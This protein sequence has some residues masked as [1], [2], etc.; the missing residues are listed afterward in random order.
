[1]S[2]KSA[3]IDG[4]R[5]LGLPTDHLKINKYCGPDDPC[6]QNVYP[7]I[8]DIAQNAVEKVQQRVNPRTI[9]QDNSGIPQENIECLQ[10]LFLT[11]PQ[12]DLAA[13]KRSKGKRV[14][15]TCEWLLVQEQYTAWLVEKKAQLLRLVGG[16]GIGKTMISTFLVKELE[17]RARMSPAVTFAYYFCD[18]KDEKRNTATA[19]VRGLLLQLIRQQHNLLRYIQPDFNQMKNGLFDNLDALWRIL[20]KI[21]GDLEAG[22]IYLLVDALDECTNPTR[23]ILLRSLADL[24]NSS[25]TGGIVNV[26]LL[27]T[28]RPEVDIESELS[29]IGGY[30]RV[31]SAKIN[32]DLSKF[33]EVR[34]NDLSRK[35]NYSDDLKKIVKEALTTKAEGTFLWVSLVQVDLEKTRSK[36]QVKEKLKKLPRNLNDVYDRILKQTETDDIE[37]AQFILRCMAVARRPLTGR[38]VDGL[39]LRIRR[40]DGK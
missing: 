27:I 30:L 26:K 18:N 35:K 39:C 36:H 15:G 23:E 13:I 24:F 11:N 3:C 29:D 10:S 6:F 7:A 31:D 5:K 14:E 9:V 22:E 37:A 28:C 16:P 33:I 8:R 32:S 19:I 1:V 17:E 12:D 40:V 20:L 2:E 4:H 25:Q 38:T 34:V 21:L